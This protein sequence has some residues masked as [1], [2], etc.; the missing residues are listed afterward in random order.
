MEKEQQI[1]K[2]I[3]SI[4]DKFGYDFELD[5]GWKGNWVVLEYQQDRDGTGLPSGVLDAVVKSMANIGYDFIRMFVCI[6]KEHA[7]DIVFAIY[8]E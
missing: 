6:D 5:E 3:N 4:R 8:E 7:F 1:R 2:V